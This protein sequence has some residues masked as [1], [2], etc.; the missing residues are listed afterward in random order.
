MRF[1][2]LG[3]LSVT[4]GAREIAVTAGR[5]RVVLATLLLR[6]GRIVGVDELIDALWA[7][8][9]PATARGQLQTCVS[10][11]RRTLPQGTILTDPAGYGIS[12]GWSTPPAAP[13]TRTPAG[14]SSAGRWISGAATRWPASTAPR[15]GTRPARS[16]SS[17]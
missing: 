5:D 10:R 16:T 8:D 2:I 9:P 17:G 3:P 12:P 4:D 11:L 15:S 1:G 13:P 6:P 7:D 14:R